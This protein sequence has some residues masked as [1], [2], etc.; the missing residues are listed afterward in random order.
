MAAWR[1]TFKRTEKCVLAHG[2]IGHLHAFT[3]GNLADAVHKI[4]LSIKDD[5]RAACSDGYVHFLLRA[6]SPDHVRAQMAGPLAQ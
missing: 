4:L 3:A 1:Q 2:V 5:M 6:H